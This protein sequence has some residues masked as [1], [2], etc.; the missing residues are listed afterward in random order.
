MVDLFFKQILNNLPGGAIVL[1]RRTVKFINKFAL[2]FLKIKSKIK[3]T[4]DIL[5]LIPNEKI[6]QK[7]F[8]SF[9]RAKS[10][11]LEIFSKKTKKTFLIEKLQFDYQK[12]IY[13]LICFRIYEGYLSEFPKF[14]ER[15]QFLR[16]IFDSIHVSLTV[17][18]KDNHFIFFNKG[19]EE[20]TGYKASEVIGKEKV[21]WIYKDPEQPKRILKKIKKQGW[22]HLDEVALQTKKGNEIFVELFI[23]NLIIEN[24]VVGSIGVGINITK[25]KHAEKHSKYLMN[26][27][28]K[29][30]S[31]LEFSLEQLKDS[32]TKLNL[33]TK[34]YSNMNLELINLNKRLEETLKHLNVILQNSLISII[35]TDKN[36]KI[37]IFNRGA[38]KLLGFSA[39]EALKRGRISDFIINNRNI[40]NLIQDLKSGLKSTLL[41][42]KHK[43]GRTIPVN[44]YYSNIK[45]NLGNKMGS[46]YIAIDISQQIKAEAEIIKKKASLEITLEELET[47]YEEIQASNDE[48]ERK[49]LELQFLNDELKKADMIKDII[50]QNIT[51]ELKTPLTSI[52]GFADI[53]RRKSKKYDKETKEILSILNRNAERLLQLIND[54]LNLSILTSGKARFVFRKNNIT[55]FMKRTI[56]ALLKTKEMKDISIKTEFQDESFFVEYDS[57]KLKDALFNIISNS[58]K[59]SDKKAIIKIKLSKIREKYAE[60][61]ISDSGVGISEVVLKKIYDRFY[62]GYTGVTKEYSGVG[63]GL[64]IVKEIVDRHFGEIKITSKKGKGTTVKILIPIKHEVH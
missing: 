5:K 33:K 53:L 35:V 16:H 58:V 63:I 60:I 10:K 40:K 11:T 59:F 13:T 45:D 3:K 27:L 15:E 18:D 12:Q 54:F 38:E 32:N 1:E 64:A 46:I 20:L 9:L 19:A 41:E 43:S 28:Q 44:L 61:K 23:S 39:K 30:N 2:N 62:T 55:A 24:E 50:L 57:T 42:M 36:A 48:L 8:S 22:V 37:K 4:R 51:H 52:I 6:F 14:Q 34:Q 17:I 29:T 56:Q 21:F 49:N 26:I 7:E 25:R 47:M 31:K